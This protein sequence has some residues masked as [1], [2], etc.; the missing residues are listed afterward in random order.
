MP[1]RQM[2]P[3]DGIIS[4]SLFS[5]Y[6]VTIDYP[7]SNLNLIKGALNANDES[8][9]LFSQEARVINTQVDIDGNSMEAHLDSGNPGFFAIP[10]ILKDKL[11]FKE[12]PVEDGVIRTPGAEFK[13]W[14]AQL[15]GDITVGNVVFK[16]PTIEL[17]E[18]F[19][20]VNMGFGFLSQVVTTIDR[21]NGLIRFK[22]SMNGV[23][24][25][26]IAES[27]S[28][29]SE[30]NEFV[31]WYGGKVRQVLGQSRCT[32]SKQTE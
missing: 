30:A 2:L 15:D 10:F 16:E 7:G 4:P 18:G 5:D 13:K 25:F 21:K 29:E 8:V 3:A 12:D 17:V 19:S 24:K 31:G 26:D 6:L 23:Q 32:I 9:V 14:K 22:P 1:L 28:T 11:S 20:F 27:V